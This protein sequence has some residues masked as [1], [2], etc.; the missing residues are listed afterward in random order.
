MS[1]TSS[2]KSS[3]SGLRTS[4]AALSIVSDNV[5][6][7]DTEGYSRKAYSQ[8]TLVLVDG[9]SSGAVSNVNFRQVDMQ[10]RKQ[11]RTESGL[12]QASYV[13]SYYLS[14]V[15]NKMGTP[16]AERSI[17]N[18]MASIQTAFETLG[19]D[20]DKLNSKST[21][22]S[23]VDTAITQFSD[24][25]A[26]IQSVRKEADQAITELCGEVTDILQQ[27]D[28]LN[29]DIVRCDSTGQS[30]DNF[31]DR[32]DMLIT[33]LSEIMDIQSYERASGETVILTAGGK[34]L[35]DKDAKVMSHTPA[36]AMGSLISYSAGSITGIYVGE[37]D[38]TN[39]IGSGELAGLIKLR[40]KEVQDLQLQLDELA[41]QLTTSMNAVS[42]K[43]TSYPNMTYEMTGSRTFIDG[44][45]QSVAVSGGDVKIVL[46]D[47]DGHEAFKTSLTGDLN[48]TSGTVDTL[49][50]TIQTWLRSP[51]EADL[52]N[53][54]CEVDADGHFH[55]DLADSRYSIAFREESS[56]LEG[57]SETN[58][59]MSFDA[60][61]NGSYD[62]DVQGFTAFFGLNDFIVVPHEESVYDS[63]IMSASAIMGIKGTTTLHFSNTEYGLD[64]GSVQ[65]SATDNIRTIAEKINAAMVDS[66]GEQ[67]VKAE[68]LR[69][70]AGYRLRISDVKDRQLEITETYSLL[71]DGVTQS[72]S[73]LKRLEMERSHA[74]FAQ[75]LK[76]RS[77]VLA[78]PAI[79]AT[80]KAQYSIESGE[81]YLSDSDNSIANDYCKIFTGAATFSAA[82]DF[83]KTVTTLR[84]YAASIVSD[85]ATAINDA[86]SKYDYQAGLVETLYAKEQDISGVDLDE[87]LSMMLLYQRTYSAA[88]K[89]L[90]TTFEML[91]LLDSIV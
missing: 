70:G 48:F 47:E 17:S 26:E 30:S 4:Q 51:T 20:A 15:Q 62:R 63:Q 33:R 37:Y 54:V 87:E 38:V 2:I 73:V 55:I 88:A 76:I 46:F 45:A 91:E 66:A 53:A 77:D 90:S 13:R 25:T 67:I 78:R 14:L 86:D 44:S 81:Y 3:L 8:H 79:F 21:A 50:D 18:R 31:R 75:G 40:D 7:V 82:G 71:S 84:D 69:E 61:G 83:S 42:S 28:K 52:A 23:A 11:Y 65:I 56:Y 60:D 5:N 72:G 35:L 80:G 22:I 27:L 57:S 29:D 64:F 1:L 34:A 19:A 12:M 68:V 36:A 9:R 43:A 89:V 58:V 16:D 59:T 85:I 10:L 41:Y 49:A 32:R 74:G 6:N 39:E 24:L